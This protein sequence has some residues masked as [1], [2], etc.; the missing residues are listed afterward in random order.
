M[1]QLEGTKYFAKIDICQAFYRI[2]ISEDSE[3]LTTF[4]TRFG[5]LV[6]R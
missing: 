6:A 5:T 1:A 4:L 2:R 3:E